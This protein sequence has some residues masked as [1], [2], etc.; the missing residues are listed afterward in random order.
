MKSYKGE[1]LS[2]FIEKLKNRAVSTKKDEIIEKATEIK[3]NK[4]ELSYFQALSLAVSLVIMGGSIGSVLTRPSAK[5]QNETKVVTEL[6]NGDK[7]KLEGKIFDI[8]NENLSDES[9]TL[10]DDE[11]EKI[12]V[13]VEE[14][15]IYV[16]YKVNSTIQGLN[17]RETPEIYGT[18]ITEM[19]SGDTIYVNDD[20][21]LNETED[22]Y[23]WKKVLYDK[24]GYNYEGYASIVDEYV[25]CDEMNENVVVKV[26]LKNERE[27]ENK[28]P[29]NNYENYDQIQQNNETPENMQADFESMQSDMQLTDCSDKCEFAIDVSS[30]DN[31]DTFKKMIDTGKFKSVIFSIGT[32]NQSENF[33]QITIPDNTEEYMEYLNT[34]N[35]VK[36]IDGPVNEIRDKFNQNKDVLDNSEYFIGHRGNDLKQFRSFVE[37]AI[38]KGV[39]VGFYY[40]SLA[41]NINEASAEAAYINAVYEN[42]KMN[43]DGFEQA[44]KLPFT[45]D[46]ECEIQGGLGTRDNCPVERSRAVEE[47]VRLLGRGTNTPGAWTIGEHDPKDGYGI[48]DKDFILY[49]DINWTS[50][51][52]RKSIKENLQLEKY[53]C[54]DWYTRVLDNYKGYPLEYRHTNLDEVL[55]VNDTLENMQYNE[56]YQKHSDLVANGDFFQTYL[57]QGISFDNGQTEGWYDF[58]I[59]QKGT[60]DA[61]CEGKEVNNNIWDIVNEHFTQRKTQDNN[62]DENDFELE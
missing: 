2:K 41:T 31:F 47:I 23:N 42:M 26:K 36:L 4:I 32:T 25:H 13:P 33:A 24:D 19:S 14:L 52:N 40:Y 22:S 57:E 55:N 61:I 37:Y 39:T 16:P 17:L 50:F 10:E 49:E 43:I 30:Y 20:E 6:A 15:D 45:I 59:A 38:Q 58:N 7:D 53:N 48:I 34:K 8:R 12:S 35:S 56:Y 29:V 51:I 9:I 44:K 28:T 62:L 1:N 60:F 3:K 46:I 21:Q 18:L 5:Q 27:Q 54:Y 11:G